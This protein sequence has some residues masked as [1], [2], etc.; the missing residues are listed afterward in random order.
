MFGEE[1]N[2]RRHEVVRSTVSGPAGGSIVRYHLQVAK[3]SQD[4]PI[5]LQTRVVL[6]SLFR[7]HMSCGS[8]FLH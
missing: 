1:R 2:A 7:C 4:G 6:A 3:R 5:T 8:D